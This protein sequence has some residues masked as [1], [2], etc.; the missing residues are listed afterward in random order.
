[1]HNPCDRLSTHLK[2]SHVDY[3]FLVALLC[4]FFGR[5]LPAQEAGQPA[6]QQ[7]ASKQPTASVGQSNA[8]RA[9]YLGGTGES[10]SS[11]GMKGANEGY[12]QEAGYSQYEQQYGQQ[13]GQYPAYQSGM[14]AAQPSSYSQ[15]EQQYGQ[16]EGQYPAFQ[17]GTSAAQPS[18][19]AD[20]IISILLQA[21]DT[22]TTFKDLAAQDYGVDPSTIPENGVY[23]CIRQDPSFR[24]QVARQLID[25]GYIANPLQQARGAAGTSRPAPLPPRPTEQP[26]E[27]LR[28]T[29]APY[30][31][32]P[33]VQNLYTQEVPTNARLRRFGSD[34][35]L[36][37]TGNTNLLPMD[38]PVGPDYVLGPGDNLI[39]NMWG[40]QSA[41][42]SRTVDRQ[43]E[44]D[45]SEAGTIVVSGLTIA[46]AQNAV[47]RALGT[48]FQNEHVELSLGR[49]RTVRVYVVGD[50][51]RP[52]A[53]D[54]SS[55]STP[56]NALYAA[57]GPTSRGSLRMLKQYRGDQLV[58]EI[59]LYDF[60]LHGV[61]SNLDRLLPGD[62]ILVPPVGPQVSVAGMVRRP[63]I[64][65]LK[66]KEDL[67]DVLELAGGVLVSADLKEIRV[68][69]VVAHER[70]TM[71]NVQLSVGPQG[72]TAALSAFQVQ[73]GD[74]IQVL[75]IL[76][77]NEQPV[78][79]DGHVYRPGRYPWREGMTVNDLLHS[80]QDVMPEPANHAEI[81]R[82]VPPDLH[83]ETISF[84]LPDAL[85]GNDPIKL[86]PFDTVRV[87]GRYNID[88]PTVSI[89]GEVLRPG[90]YPMSQGMTVADLVKMAGGFKHSAY[91]KEADLSSYVIQNGQKVLVNHSNVA[92][93]KALEGDTGTDV[94]LKPGDVLSIRRLAGWQDIG[95]SVTINGEVEHAG[96]YGI[97]DGERLSSVLKRAG[98][99]RA[100]AYPAAAVLERVQ[101]RELA[102][103]AR[104]QMI[105]RIEN[106]PVPAN[107]GATNPQA[108]TEMQQ[109]M[110]MQRQQILQALRSHPASGRL[111]IAIDS[112]I[113]KWENTPADIELRA[114][115]T[116]LIPKRPNFVGVNG[117]V[118]NP[119]A[120]SYVPGRD[121]DWYLK[122]AGGPT[123]IGDKKNI[124]VLR[125]DG[126]VVVLQDQHSIWMGFG[127][128]RMHPGD[129]IIVPEKIIGG[130]PV[131]QNIMSTAMIGATIASPLA[132]AGVL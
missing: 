122:K 41:R 23:N 55:L 9:C 73:D 80:Y 115:D 36:F 4:A 2:R 100:D 106:T 87:F 45:L 99:F 60:L 108:A 43:G 128:V 83:P 85:I 15:Y 50:V 19:S 20:Q 78:Y 42:L 82:L 118:Y 127:N 102:E 39:V 8:P 5:F 91:R 114:G 111:V 47:Q 61:R 67:K 130:S 31:N 93:E 18:L 109:S 12:S 33:S 54:V 110:Q 11:L 7:P 51:Q 126:S 96:S 27:L 113:S 89:R 101:V 49:V 26:S 119:A 10:S 81:I 66:G 29:P 28:A 40:G 86:Q 107:A 6:G 75:P 64:Y 129:I 112:D 95:A 68:E 103:Q 16:Q 124:Y 48:Q 104:Q 57:G 94:A 77:Y 131:W 3:L 69:R 24:N 90:K 53:Y 92:I 121:L 38:L 88:P 32:L 25:Q 105:L 59:D 30:L 62:T 65:E 58:Q 125:A 132:F 63:A 17:P 21:P 1:M 123:R 117:Q 35:F 44:I 120:I 70:H 14:S 46:E 116:L 98:G 37:G 74:S 34:A 22:L 84:N 97:E 52:G 72:E 13:E 79:L 76:P 71:L 56:L